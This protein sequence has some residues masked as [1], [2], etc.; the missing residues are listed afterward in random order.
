MTIITRPV[1]DMLKPA[2]NFGG[3]SMSQLAEPYV[4]NWLRTRQSVSDLINNFSIVVVK[5]S[6]DS[7]LQ[8]GDDTTAAGDL[9]DRIE[10]FTLMRS[11]K[12]AMVVDK[13]KEEVEMLNTPLSG[14]SELQSQAQ[15]Q[16]CSVSHTPSV[17]LLGIAPSGFGNVAEGEIRT[18]NDWVMSIWEAYWR[19][20]IETVVNILQIIKYGEID[21]DIIVTPQP[22][23]QMT[24][25]ELAEIR[26]ADSTTDGSYLD[27]GV[28]DAIE[29]RE[30]LARNPESGYQGLDI[31]KVPE[32]EEIQDVP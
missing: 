27:R 2:F 14:L 10:L 5:T 24:P 9:M 12:G 3:M 4:D 8:G 32:V 30:K 22:L 7:V 19:K 1:T 15:E 20:P 16:M 18:W 17:E 31:T 26:T 25:K 29:V 21:S 6:M 23:Y 28:V 11:N 13:D